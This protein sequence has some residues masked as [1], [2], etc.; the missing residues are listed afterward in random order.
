MESNYTAKQSILKH[1]EKFKQIKG[2][3]FG[4]TNE[5]DVMSNPI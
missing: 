3:L 1:E 4:G 2:Q 5:P